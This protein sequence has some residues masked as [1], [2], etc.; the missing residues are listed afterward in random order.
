MA[1]MSKEAENVIAKLF[2][3][4]GFALLAFGSLVV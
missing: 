2:L 4:V 1:S 3:V